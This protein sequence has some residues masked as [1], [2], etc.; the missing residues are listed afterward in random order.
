M[1]KE[2]WYINE[3]EL[4]D[5]QV[6]II[7]RS[8]TSSFIVKGCAGSGKTVLAL[9][10]AKELSEQGVSSYL[11]IVFTKALKQFI[12][13]GIHAIGVDESKVMYHWEWLHNGRPSADY[14]IIDEVQD[15]SREELQ[16]LRDSA[17]KHLILFGDSAQQ[18]YAEMKD[19]LMTMEEIQVMTG[20]PME[21]LVK[22]HRLPKKIA[23]FAEELSSGVDPLAQ[24]CYKEGPSKPI[25]MKCGSLLEQIE[26]I[27]QIV[28]S[29]RYTDVG[30]L[31]ASNIDVQ[32]AKDACTKMGWKVE[33]KIGYG[34]DS[35]ELNFTTTNP[36]LMTYHS[37]K[38]LQFEAVF[39]PNCHNYED[40]LR[41]PL[42]VAATRTY[43][44]LYLMYTGEMASV[45]R[46][47]PPS[48]VEKISYNK[49]VP[50]APF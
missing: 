45:F 25:I 17:R 7:R 5:Y 28:Q 6:Q 23:K 1:A 16:Q 13:D 20:I 12:Q 49:K 27:R 42:Y 44:Y 22:N 40:Y 3:S 35:M 50:Q 26:A 31:F 19:D 43:R 48:L 46:N 30:I 8:L 38:G 36:K 14:I 15:F 11:V 32:F 2:A 33:A 47:I 29:Q 41:N 4:D 9:W 24:R 10:R 21:N 39:I 34:R 37:S 18:V